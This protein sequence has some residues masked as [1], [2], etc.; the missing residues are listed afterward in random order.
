[1]F[2][3]PLNQIE[4]VQLVIN[5]LRMAGGEADC[6][7]CPANRACLKQCLT[8]A[9]AVARMVDA[10]NLPSLGDESHEPASTPAGEEKRPAP[11]GEKKDF[12]KV[13]K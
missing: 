5:A 7:S 10:G 8:I 2:F 1:M 4:S 13:I 11:K 9:D 6:T 12:L 3:I